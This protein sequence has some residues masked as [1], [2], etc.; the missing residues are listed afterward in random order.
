MCS[1]LCSWW[2][3]LFTCRCSWCSPC[4]MSCRKCSVSSPHVPCFDALQT[5]SGDVRYRTDPAASAGNWA[6]LTVT[7]VSPRPASSSPWTEWLPN[8][9]WTACVRS[10][11]KRRGQTPIQINV[12]FEIN[13]IKSKNHLF[14][15]NF[16][17]GFTPTQG[18]IHSACFER[19]LKATCRIIIQAIS[20]FYCLL[21]YMPYSDNEKEANQDTM[22]M[23]HRTAP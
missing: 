12:R 15:S 1:W 21:L 5:S 13:Q 18:C 17:A 3:S 19:A 11:Y 6:T 22:Q 4:V 9:W 16:I 10:H 20:C 2:G 8:S 14:G 7:F 23:G